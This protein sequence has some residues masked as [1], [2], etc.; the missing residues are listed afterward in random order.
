MI[1]LY[2][3]T[4]SLLNLAIWL[5]AP[6]NSKARLWIEG[7][8]HPE[9]VLHALPQA[10]N[11]KRIWVHCS[12]LGEFEQSRPLIEALRRQVPDYLMVLSF[13]SPSGYEIRKNYKG[14]DVVCYMPL[15]G[16][17]RSKDFLDL[18]DPALAIFIK[19]ESWYH[20]LHELE[21]R[22]IPRFLISAYFTPHQVFF[23]PW[24]G[25][26]KMLLGKYSHIFVQDQASA[27]LLQAGNI[28][29]PIT[30]AGDTRFDQVTKTAAASFDLPEFQKF[31]DGH[32]VIV[33]GS[34]WPK[35]EEMLA[36]VHNHFPDAKL[37]IAP[38]NVDNLSI[39][40]TLEKFSNPV[41]HSTLTQEKKP[42]ESNVLV[43]DSIGMLSK[44]YRFA[45]VC[46]VGGGFNKAGIHNILEAAVYN[47]LVFFGP[48]HHRS[49]E[50]GKMLEQGAAFSISTVQDLIKR[51][52]ELNG[53]IE[54]VR[55]AGDKAGSFVLEN[56]GATQK[57]MD[58]LTE[59]YL[60]LR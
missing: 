42:T 59:H 45:S 6:W 22:G 5:A 50:A 56:T 49:R 27:D 51:L 36:R 4:L 11:K 53:D 18:V 46:Y 34:T 10:A 8:K 12:S 48:H 52:I 47:K 25:F 7:R 33:A 35:D 17:K 9:K 16:R 60:C 37:I 44:L 40:N 28:P 57:I 32:F 26:F 21:A 29:L 3:L 19:Y 31:C 2:D 24:G 20:Y 38:H 54:G 41:R 39:E 15:D 14:V 23:K 58:Y 43:I 30:V 1:F 13:F 55:S